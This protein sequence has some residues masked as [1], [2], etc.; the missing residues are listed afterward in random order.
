MVQFMQFYIFYLITYFYTV[1]EVFTGQ[2][3]KFFTKDFGWDLMG[4][5]MTLP[6]GLSLYFLQSYIGTS[7]F[8]LLGVPFILITLLIRFYSDSEKVNSDLNKASEFGHELAERM[9]GKEIIDM[10]I[11]TNCQYVP[12]GFCLYC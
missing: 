5:L 3:P 1:R 11:D 8:W 4:L 2:K 10:F 12:D 9:T 7:A 6:F